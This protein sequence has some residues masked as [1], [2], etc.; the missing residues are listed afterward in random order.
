MSAPLSAPERWKCL[1]AAQGSHRLSGETYKQRAVIRVVQPHDPSVLQHG[2]PNRHISL[3]QSQ[4]VLAPAAPP[5]PA[6]IP[7]LPALLEPA[8]LLLP[9]APSVPAAGVLGEPAASVLEPPLPAPPVAPPLPVLPE[10]PLVAS[11]T[12]MPPLPATDSLAVAPAEPDAEGHN[13]HSEYEPF[14]GEFASAAQALVPIETPSGHVH[15]ALSP[16]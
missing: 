5:L 1:V 15:G 7:A 8:E 6:R 14:V 16:K 9:A 3:L 10:R 12:V 4:P 13:R 2:S 11:A